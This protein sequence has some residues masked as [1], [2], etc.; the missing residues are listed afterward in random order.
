MRKISI[1]AL[2]MLVFSLSSLGCESRTQNNSKTTLVVWGMELGQKAAGLRARVDAFQKMHPNIRV[3]ILSMGA[4]SMDP[5]KLM[6]AIVGKVP[7]DVIYQDRFTIGD[8]ASRGTFLPL[9][10]LLASNST[11]PYLSLIHI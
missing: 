9:D 7:P 5:Q 6:T 2:T 3:S 11:G 8:W 1:L 10:R 4:G